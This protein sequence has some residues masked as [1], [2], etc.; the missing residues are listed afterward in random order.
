ML[1]L[2]PS[3]GF[4]RARWEGVDFQWEAVTIRSDE[5]A[6]SLIRDALPRV[7]PMRAYLGEGSVRWSDQQ[8]LDQ[9]AHHLAAQRL[10]LY[11]KVRR[12]VAL[13][14]ATGSA[15][16]A[17]EPEPPKT[18]S[19]K[20]SAAP[21]AARKGSSVVSP[22]S[23]AVPESDVVSIDQ[24]RQAEALVRAAENGTPFCAVCE[25]ARQSSAVAPQQAAAA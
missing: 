1:G 21:V 13:E 9:L 25:A 14:S 17:P 5:H 23:A 8:V 24:D 2:A 4:G 7:H 20:S 11:K 10:T 16:A 22:S 12:L 19:E 3:A 15:V 6:R 18:A